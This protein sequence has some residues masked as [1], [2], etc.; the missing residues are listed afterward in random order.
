[1]SAVSGPRDLS[2]DL[3]FCSQPDQ[4]NTFG[5]PTT[6]C[7]NW[8]QSQRCL[9]GSN[10]HNGSFTPHQEDPPVALEASSF[11]E[12]DAAPA[13]VTCYDVP[14]V[15]VPSQDGPHEHYPMEQHSKYDHQYE[16][17]NGFGQSFDS[18]TTGYSS[19]WD[20][21]NS[22]SSPFSEPFARSED[23]GDLVMINQTAS[24]IPPR[25]A[26]Y[27]GQSQPTSQARPQT[28]HREGN[29]WYKCEAANITV[30]YSGP[31]FRI[32]NND[33]YG[34]S[35]GKGMHVIAEDAKDPR[36]HK[37]LHLETDGS[38]CP[39]KF[40]RSEHLK[41]HRSKHD[42]N[43][44]KRFACPLPNCTLKTPMSRSDNAAQHL[45]THLRQKKKGKR[46]M[47]Y[48]WEKVKKLVLE[49]F[50]EKTASRMVGSL[51]RWLNK[52]MCSEEYTH[53]T[54]MEWHRMMERLDFQGSA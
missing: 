26:H 40:P 54:L 37:C 32:A 42:P 16:V 41:R 50:E 12:Y 51:T 46:N 43:P 1:M 10:L 47:F 11:S 44:A 5:L 33:S 3:A 48:G 35:N 21:V 18:S 24:I 13:V 8:A 7:S 29:A 52:Q 14:Q 23:D 6:M 25:L 4:T 36:P 27:Q 19:G 28:N 34:E 45:Q 31:R 53:M 20:H 22:L 39:A 2:N 9:Y 15:V 17:H 30:L 38:R 49:T